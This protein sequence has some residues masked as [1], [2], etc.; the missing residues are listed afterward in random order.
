MPNADGTLTPRENYLIAAKGGIPERIPIFGEDYNMF[1]HPCF[2]HMNEEKKDFF[3]IRWQGNEYG[4][5]PVEGEYVLSEISEWHDIVWPAVD[6]FDWSFA[7]NM[8]N[9]HY[10]PD[11][12]NIF[13]LNSHGLFLYPIQMLGWTEG[14]Y[15]LAAEP[16]EFAAFDNRL[17]DYMI[18]ILDYAKDLI[19]IDTVFMGDDLANTKGP[20]ISPDTWDE[21]FKE[22]FQ[23]IVDKIHEIGALA[24]FHNCGNNDFLIG[25]MMEIGVDICQL[26]MANEALEADKKKYGSRLVLT[27]GMKD[28]QGAWNQPGASEEL[29][30]AAVREGLD[31]YASEGALIF[32]DGAM[33]NAAE[34]NDERMAWVYDEVKTYGTELCKKAREKAGIA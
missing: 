28:R 6:S 8:W 11:K 26:P 18:E 2:G 1:M 22:P 24:E 20:F 19:P 12:A 25:K 13:M 23:R 27:G 17:A 4:E 30:R 3:G 29:V 16:E 9:E 33:I 15:A 10:D 21:V 32:W 5:M 31:A 7:M 34:G 14:L